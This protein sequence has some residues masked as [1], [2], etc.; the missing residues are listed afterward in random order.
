MLQPL[1]DGLL[2]QGVAEVSEGAVIIPF[3]KSD[4]K[5]LKDQPFLIRKKDGAALY[6]TTDLATVR[7]RL[8]TWAPKR[9]LYV[10]DTR[11]QL[12]F[13][14]LF[15][16]TN[17]L[18]WNQAELVHVWFGLLS[19][20]E[21]NMSS[22]SGNVIHLKALLDAA[23][24]KAREIVDMKSAEL[25]DEERA[26][27]A[28]AVGVSAVR[29]A[30]LSQNPQANV[31]FDWDKM[32]AMEGNTAPFLMYGHARL[33]S[34][35]RKEA[36]QHIVTEHGPVNDAERELTTLLLRFPS[37]VPAALEANRPSILAEYLFT[38]ARAVNRFYSQSRIKGS[39]GVE[40]AMRASL[41]AAA[42]MTL[43]TGLGLLGIPALERM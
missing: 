23:V 41:V 19:L 26:L 27:V 17:K 42:S 12:H 16:A 8:D 9:V 10:T 11:Q 34:I 24:D 7:F 25:P 14:Q 2:A 35:Q 38:V 39:V 6:G 28:E 18:G 3:D 36:L 32:M 4:G 1:V 40:R 37:V 33:R 21:G 13:K 15:A 31:V 5:G 22:R 43:S 30:D 29:Y 20:P